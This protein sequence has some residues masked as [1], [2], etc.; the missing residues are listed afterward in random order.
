ME[1][2]DE[3]IV[4]GVRRLGESDVILEALTRH[5][6]R[7]LGVVR[8][9]RSR[10]WQPSLQAGNGLNVTWRA[11]LDEQLG[12]F[13]VE[14][15]DMRAAR[16]IEDASALYALSTIGTLLR[17]LPERDPHEALYDT[18][19]IV[20]EALGDVAMTAPLLIRFEL[21]MLGELGFGLDLNECALT[22]AR[23]GLVYVSPKTGRAVTRE[24]GEPW[25]D[26]LLSLPRFMSE[27]RA[28]LAPAADEILQGF[29][30][31]GHFLEQHIFGP[32]GLEMP[33]SRASFIALA[34]KST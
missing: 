23:D 12:M 21:A 9:G 29:A 2:S 1:W 11:R 22:G 27:G 4:I 16:F 19:K 26:R 28:D 25:K 10:R 6:G 7:H 31:T 32:R 24:A 13:T 30:I 5:H 20:L 18:V 8:G 17:L 14:P 3:A 15:I 34:S 33:E